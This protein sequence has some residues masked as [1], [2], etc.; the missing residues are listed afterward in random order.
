MTSDASGNDGPMADLDD[1]VAGKLDELDKLKAENVRRTNVLAARGQGIGQLAPGLDQILLVE[2]V[3]CIIRAGWG[4]V[5]LLDIDLHV[6]GQVATALDAME[7][8]AVKA[9]LLS[10]GVPQ[11]GQPN[12]EAR[13]HG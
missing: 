13:R 2:Y 11:N 1:D 8:E 4:E 9:H 5:A 12:R 6:Q 10:P 7:P 3:R